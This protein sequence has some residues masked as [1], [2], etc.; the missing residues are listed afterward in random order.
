MQFLRAECLAPRLLSA[1]DAGDLALWRIAYQDPVAAQ[2]RFMP[3]FK[4]PTGPIGIF[5][6]HER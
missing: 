3:I 2:I 4:T 6:L 5:S 1:S